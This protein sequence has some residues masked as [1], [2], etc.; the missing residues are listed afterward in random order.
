METPIRISQSIW[1]R[2]SPIAQRL[3]QSKTVLP[4]ALVLCAVLFW[5]LSLQG[6]DPRDMNDFGLLSILPPSF[7]VALCIIA[8]SFCVLLSRPE[9]PAG[10]MWL[11]VATWIVFIHGTPNILYGTLRYSWAWKH[12]G[13]IDYILRH[14]SINPGISTYNAYHN[15]PGFFAVG[16]FLT[17]VAGYPNALPFAG[18]TQVFFNV[19]DMGALLL[20]YRAFTE[21]GRL[22]WLSLWFF[23][24]SSWVGQDYFSPQAQNYFLLLL[25]L[26]IWLRWFSTVTPPDLKKI[27]RW[28]PSQW[29]A[30]LFHR[31]IS[32]TNP[33]RPPETTLYQ[34][35]GLIAVVIPLMAVIASSHQLTPFMLIFA[36]TLLALFY[37]CEV[38]MLPFLMLV[39]TVAWMGYM[40]EAFMQGNLKEMIESIGQLTQNA[41]STLSRVD[42]VQVS[43]GQRVIAYM[44]RGLTIGVWGLGLLGGIQ[45]LRLGHLDLAAGLLAITSFFLLATSDYGGEILFRVY[46]F[47]VPF[48]AF[49]VA[50]IFYP[51]TNWGGSWRTTVGI[52]CVSLTMLIA[53]LFAYY[54]KDR[55][56][57]FTPAEVEASQFL[58]NLAPQGSLIIDGTRNYPW[59]QNYEFY[60]YVPIANEPKESRANIMADPVQVLSRWMGNENDTAAF[61]II[62]RSQKSEVDMVGKMPAG[63]LERIEK[64]LIQSA[65]F[66]VLFANADATVFTLASRWEGKAP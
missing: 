26:G 6:I 51:R 63:S 9:P 14:Y 44:G 41:E 38:R 25:I 34:R 55:Q 57:Y 62:T 20:I 52:I 13:I 12:V 8:L 18:W 10:L 61:L 33:S 16:A 28:L 50:A 60:R 47:S 30:G 36:M 56:Y 7:Y 43:F 46:F 32:L 64:A 22:V 2:L 58:F 45:R 40:A 29:V 49:F 66:K 53:F 54:G 35:V 42:L 24:L 4:L 1:V 21:D 3:L 31:L 37:R 15:W 48:F 11:H 39:F 65:R 23:Y 59:Y 5:G 27:K 17:E 19:L